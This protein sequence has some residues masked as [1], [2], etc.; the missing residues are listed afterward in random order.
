MP[1]RADLS[2]DRL[3]DYV[4]KSKVN[5][6]ITSVPKIETNASKTIKDSLEKP[7][8]I[9]ASAPLIEEWESDSEDEN[10]FKLKED[11]RIF[12]SGCSRHM[13]GN[14]SYLIDYQENDGG[15]IAFRGNAKV[16]KITGKDLIINY[17]R[18][19]RD[20]G[21]ASI[22]T[23]SSSLGA[24]SN[25]LFSSTISSSATLACSYSASFCFFVL[26][27]SS[28]CPALLEL[29]SARV[30]FRLSSTSSVSISTKVFTPL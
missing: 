29:P 20:R 11:Q 28:S 25:H 6:T 26:S 15:F 13:T 22:A 24:I 21:V 9:R 7:K 19:F 10:V 12:D 2:F 27:C 1:L 18:R 30:F 17:G 14:K 5:K 23:S 16:G 8:T 4:F 3:D